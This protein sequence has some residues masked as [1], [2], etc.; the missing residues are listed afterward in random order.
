MASIPTVIVECPHCDHPHQVV[1]PRGQL[2]YKC[3]SFC[4]EC[5]NFYDY[6]TND[7]IPDT[8]SQADFEGLDDDTLSQFDPK[9]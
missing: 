6:T 8:D 5:G 1:S 2:E 9:A 3:E 7:I 4:F